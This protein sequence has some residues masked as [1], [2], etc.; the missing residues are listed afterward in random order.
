MNISSC[1]AL[2]GLEA[3]HSRT[4]GSSS[5]IWRQTTLLK[6]GQLIP[7]INI[8]GALESLH[9]IAS[10]EWFDVRCE[11]HDLLDQI[12]HIKNQGVSLKTLRPGIPRDPPC[13]VPNG[14]K[15]RPEFTFPM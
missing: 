5:P 11:N 9:D 15:V 13:L 6:L 3:R 14:D 8:N 4:P 1:F 2:P 7:H 12:K 10:K